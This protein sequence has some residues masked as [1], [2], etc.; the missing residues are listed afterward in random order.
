MDAE[1]RQEWEAIH[2]E[3]ERLRRALDVLRA[4]RGAAGTAPVPTDRAQVEAIREQ[5]RAHSRRV[6]ARVESARSVPV[7]PIRS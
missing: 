5:V 4:S 3:T 2:A 1:E 6:L 7:G